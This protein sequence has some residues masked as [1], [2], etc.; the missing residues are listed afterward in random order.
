MN[1]FTFHNTFQ[2]SKFLKK[3]NYKYFPVM[4]LIIVYNNLTIHYQSKVQA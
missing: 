2:Y 3:T 4:S 1:D